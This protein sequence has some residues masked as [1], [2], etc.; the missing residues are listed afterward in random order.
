MFKYTSTYINIMSFCISI[1]VFVLITTIQANY[2]KNDYSAVL[3]TSFDVNNNLDISNDNITENNIEDNLN[4]IETANGNLQEKEES[5]IE[6]TENATKEIQKVTK[7]T[8]WYLEIPCINLKAEIAEGTT[9]QI[10]SKYIGH[11]EETS[12]T[13]GNV[14]LAAHNRG[15]E[16][17]YFE[18]LKYLKE[19]DE[20]IYKC[21][22]F[23]K[24]YI[25]ES[26]TIIKDTDWS[27]LENNV[28]KD[29]ITLI[30]CVE[31]QPEYRRCIQGIEE[32]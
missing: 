22:E 20:I 32:N 29:T 15:Y 9:K 18:N 3:R 28:E 25:V 31:N 2:K 11:F 30:T 17:N 7:D 6:D 23:Y 4:E 5:I 14:G 19:G 16:N 1:V 12:K 13:S 26:H 27:N 10:M 8:N 21:N 24:K